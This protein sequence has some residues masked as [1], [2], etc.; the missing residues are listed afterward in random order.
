MTSKGDPSVM[1]RTNRMLNRIYRKLKAEN[2]NVTDE[3]DEESAIIRA[4]KLTGLNKQSLLNLEC[5]SLEPKDNVN[6][7]ISRNCIQEALK[8]FVLQKQKLPTTLELF[9]AVIDSLP[10]HTDIHSFKKKLVQFDFVWKYIPSSNK[11]VVMERPCVTYERYSYLKRFLECADGSMSIFFIDELVIGKEKLY[12]L[13]DSL[14][15]TE[16]VNGR[17]IYAA[18]EEGVLKRTVDAFNEFEFKL[19]LVE[20]LLPELRKPSVIVIDNAEHHCE[21]FVTSKPSFDSLKDDLK[22]WLDKH[23]VPY[24]NSMSR[25]ELYLL[26]ERCTNKECSI[27]VIDNIL[28]DHGH[29]LLRLP[30]D[31]YFPTPTTYLLNTLETKYKDV[32]KLPTSWTQKRVIYILDSIASNLLI[33]PF[34][35]IINIYRQMFNDDK[36]VD[37]VLDDVI[38]N[39]ENNTFS[40]DL[41]SDIPDLSDSE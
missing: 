36:E 20:V 1:S 25:A 21:K 10:F 40:G 12:N 32:D 31:V 4:S 6:R 13:Q 16:D 17:V 9:D 30:N 37:D 34:H 2:V 5:H 15:M 23:N 27:Y 28:R 41:D 24:D 33:P 26:T 29:V 39:L 14:E 3:V 18:S 8:K 7:Q 22:T 11:L 38:A 19:F 35:R